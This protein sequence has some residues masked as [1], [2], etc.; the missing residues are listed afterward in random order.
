MESYSNQ[1]IMSI[2]N[3]LFDEKVA[4]MV[5][6]NGYK[7]PDN[8]L[9]CIYT[10]NTFPLDQCRIDSILEAWEDEYELPPISVI[11]QSV[12]RFIVLN[13][14]HRLAVAIMNG[15]EYINTNKFEL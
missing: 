5:E 11:R 3:L 15:A 7:F 12:N 10:Q 8:L 9:K 4:D 14:R 13:G 6:K 1:D 2:S